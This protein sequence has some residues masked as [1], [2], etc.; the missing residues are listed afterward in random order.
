MWPFPA[1]SGPVPKFLQ[2]TVSVSTD[3]AGATPANISFT[4]S[5]APAVLSLQLVTNVIMIRPFC[6]LHL[7]LPW[8][9]KYPSRLDFF[10]WEWLDVSLFLQVSGSWAN[11]NWVMVRRRGCSQSSLKLLC[12]WNIFFWEKLDIF[13]WQGVSA[14]FIFLLSLFWLFLV[15]WHFSNRI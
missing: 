4:A 6:S 8:L 1:S 14:G 13:S 11:G 9:L 15:S 5:E 3:W 12:I 10:K 7:T 2:S